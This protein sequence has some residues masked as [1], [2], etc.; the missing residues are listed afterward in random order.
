M[1]II[2]SREPKSI[3]EYGQNFFDGK[4]HVEIQELPEGDFKYKNVIVERKEINDFV[5]SII[6]KRMKNQK[7]KLIE[8]QKDGYHCYVIIMGDY[9]DIDGEHSLSKKAIAGAIASLNEY[10]IHTIHTRRY[11]YEMLFEV[12]YG[13][14]RKF[15][16][17][18]VISE[19]FV[20]PSGYSWTMK[21]LMCIDG[22]GKETAK[23]II[24][25]LPHLPF[26]YECSKENLKL[27]LLEVEGVGNK[28]AD[29]II[30]VLYND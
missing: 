22:V 2:D 27:L 11:D 14:M 10:G 13:L 23:N 28:T 21:S 15:N 18:K 6:D 1:M 12:I 25:K 8:K 3:Q 7:K 17:D 24:E 26:F 9:K 16:E 5:S 29:K 20:E 30:E 4:V 19:V